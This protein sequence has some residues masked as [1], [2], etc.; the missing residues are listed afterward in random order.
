MHP[1]CEDSEEMGFGFRFRM[2]CSSSE[3]L[4]YF[5]LISIAICKG[6]FPASVDCYI[7]KSQLCDP[8]LAVF[9]F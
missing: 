1:L 5:Y 3:Q 7:A 6:V 9:P 8:S 2:G 4:V